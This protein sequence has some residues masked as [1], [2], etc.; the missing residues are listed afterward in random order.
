MGSQLRAWAAGVTTL[1]LAACASAPPA[2]GPASSGLARALHES[3]MRAAATEP[4]ASFC[5]QL[6][7]GIAERDWMRGQV[8]ALN[9]SAIGVRV[10][11]AGRFPKVVDRTFV[12]PGAV[13]WAAPGAWTPC[14]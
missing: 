5:R 12:L 10:R 6:M 11:D 13:L 7:V 4:N 9:D 1:A 8:V 2:G 3:A 14:A